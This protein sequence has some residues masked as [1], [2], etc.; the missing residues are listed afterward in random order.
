[1]FSVLAGL[2]G[3]MFLLVSPFCGTLLKNCNLHLT[4]SFADT[5]G[6]DVANELE[7]TIPFVSTVLLPVKNT[8]D[9]GAET[10]LIFVVYNVITNRFCNVRRDYDGNTSLQYL[11]F[12]IAAITALLGLA[13][14][15]VGDY[16]QSIKTDDGGDSG[17]SVNLA[18]L[19]E[20]FT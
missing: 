15:G 10:T 18:N 11:H 7:S 3:A 16:A 14:A 17:N 2:L 20:R 19:L 9:N 8:I 4:S 1:M 6:I 12:G 5:T 13:D